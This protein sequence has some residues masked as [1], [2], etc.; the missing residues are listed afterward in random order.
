MKI[1]I[2]LILALLLLFVR[3][4]EFFNPATERPTRTDESLRRAVQTLTAETTAAKVDKYITILEK[5]YDEKYLPDKKTPEPTVVSAFVAGLEADPDVNREKLPALIDYIFLSVDGT[6]TTIPDPYCPA[7]FTL[8]N[9]IGK[10]VP[11]ESVTPTCAT[12][13]TFEDGS[14]KAT[15][16]TQTAITNGTWVGAQT[17][18]PT[19]PSGFAYQA[20]TKMCSAPVQDPKCMQPYTFVMQPKADNPD[21]PVPQCVSPTSGAT[22]GEAEAAAAGT[23]GTSG[24]S[25]TSESASPRGQDVFGPL[26]TELGDGVGGLDVDTTQIN[27]YPTLIGGHTAAGVMGG[28]GAGGGQARVPKIEFPSLRSL[29]LNGMSQFFPFSRSPGDMDVVPDPF[30][31]NRNFSTASYASK[32]EPVPFL[33]DFSAFFK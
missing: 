21:T 27:K 32:N 14:C 12:G 1:W 15:S 28:G 18:E 20:T 23:A 17:V 10:C 7:R 16:A 5:Y 6:V 24:T 11:E 29:G 26:Y 4:R 13:F 22:S 31:V 33:T 19:C 30:R 3:R 9:S 2:L 25:G 8:D